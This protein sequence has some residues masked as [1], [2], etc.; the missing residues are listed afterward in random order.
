[1]TDWDEK[2]LSGSGGEDIPLRTKQWLT[3]THPT[4][5][6]HIFTNSKITFPYSHVP[7]QKHVRSRCQSDVKT[8]ILFVMDKGFS[9]IYEVEVGLRVEGGSRVR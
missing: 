5:T 8:C 7:F 6:N 3:E 9:T 1:M 2:V 4:L